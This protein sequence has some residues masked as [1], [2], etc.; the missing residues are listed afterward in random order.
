MKKFN[1]TVVGRT[2][3]EEH[4][5]RIRYADTLRQKMLKQHTAAA[6]Q[7]RAVEFERGCFLAGHCSERIPSPLRRTTCSST[8]KEGNGL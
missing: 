8:R 5:I 2:G 1:N 6:R 3:G 4:V 7:L